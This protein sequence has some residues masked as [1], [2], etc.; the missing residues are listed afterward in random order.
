MLCVKRCNCC[1]AES[2]SLFD[3]YA[4]AVGLRSSPH[5]RGSN[6]EKLREQCSPDKGR[7]HGRENHLLC[8]HVVAHIALIG[9]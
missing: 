5:L 9:Y 4:G 6:F 2:D 1:W 3:D 8:H 7:S